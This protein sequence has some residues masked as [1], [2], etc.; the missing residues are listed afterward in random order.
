MADHPPF[1]LAG[2]AYTRRPS[3]SLQSDQRV[4]VG[5]NVQDQKGRVSNRIH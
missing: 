5:I 2:A 1:P 4:R 3:R